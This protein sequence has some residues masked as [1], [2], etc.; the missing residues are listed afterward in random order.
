MD[1]LTRH[2]LK[3]DKFVEEVG[4]TVHFL[5]E[6]RQ[7]L[8]RYGAVALV[9]LVLAAAGYYYY[10]TKRTERQQALYMAIETYNAPVSPTAPPNALKW[11]PTAEER[12]K[13]VRK[14]LGELISKYSGSEEAA[15]ASYLLGLQ[16]ADQGDVAQAERYLKAAIQDGGKEYAALAKYAL[17]QMYNSEG[18]AGEAEAL[19]RELISAPSV[20]VSKEQATIT[21]ARYLAKSRPEEARKL[22]DPLRADPG[23]VG[24]IAI[25][26]YSEIEQARKN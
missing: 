23:T 7:Q 12:N 10:R 16:A 15:V 8:I 2:E 18:R 25:S 3:A 26:A 21:L 4:Q 17:A 24:R 9:V 11:F 14:E 20:L 6:H 5:E 22:L 1:R 19:L 13:A